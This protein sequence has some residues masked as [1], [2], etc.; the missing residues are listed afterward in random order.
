M[1]REIAIM[2]MVVYYK[3]KASEEGWHKEE[4]VV[5]QVDNSIDKHFCNLMTSGKIVGLQ[6]EYY[7]D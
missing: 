7:E 5:T 2:R 3:V 6:I 1:K 4:H